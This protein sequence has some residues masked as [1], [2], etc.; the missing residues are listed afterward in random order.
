[1]KRRVVTFIRHGESAHNPYIVRGKSTDPWD[2]AILNEGRRMLNPAL[3]PVGKAQA[4]QLRSHLTSTQAHYD[5]AVTT[6]LYRAIETATIALEGLCD[7]YMVTSLGCETA[8]PELGSAQKGHSKAEML[9]TY[10]HLATWDMSRLV[11]VA[12]KRKPDP[13]HP[14]P[15]ANV[16][17]DGG[18]RLGFRQLSRTRSG[19]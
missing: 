18:G 17:F 4:S 11:E 19:R 1:M 2:H 7:R 5:I 13:N 15:T 3:T 6:P 14:N 8:K 16:S 9:A 12:H 10:P